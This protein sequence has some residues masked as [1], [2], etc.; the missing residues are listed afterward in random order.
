[1]GRQGR[2]PTS[3]PAVWAAAAGGTGEIIVTL[4]RFRITALS[5][6]LLITSIYTAGVCDNSSE[7]CKCIDS[8]RY[9]VSSPLNEDDDCVYEVLGV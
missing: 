7:K 9:Y 4:L 1:M 3:L 8:L 6:Q 5:L 2:R